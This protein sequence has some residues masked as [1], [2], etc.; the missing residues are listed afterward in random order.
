MWHML[1]PRSAHSPA[2]VGGVACETMRPPSGHA[3]LTLAP[4]NSMVPHGGYRAISQPSGL[5]ALEEKAKP[6][7]AG[8]VFSKGFFIKAL[9]RNRDTARRYPPAT[10]DDRRGAAVMCRAR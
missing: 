2:R 4:T 8:G 3:P 9:Q 7:P 6:M 5:S 10:K 1:V